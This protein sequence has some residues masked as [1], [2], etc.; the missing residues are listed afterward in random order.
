VEAILPIT[1]VVP[2]R[3]GPHRY[4]YTALR[5]VAN[6]VSRPHLHRQ[7]KEQ[8]H[9]KRRDTTNTRILVVHGLGGSGKSQLVLNYVQ[10]YRDDYLTIF[11][12]A[13]GQKESIERDYLQIYRLLFNLRP[14]TGPDA[15]R[16]KDAV[17]AVKGV[18]SW[19]DGAVVGGFR[20][21][22]RH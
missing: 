12:V 11:W 5:P 1:A 22:G 15:A 16:I 2:G 13:A 18:V 17:A 19:S 20:Q 6:Y 8:L 14:V 3:A 4:S 7:I 21:C 9:D 10:E